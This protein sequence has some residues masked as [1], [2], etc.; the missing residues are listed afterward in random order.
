M[1]KLALLISFLVLPCQ[2]VGSEI[3]A[4]LCSARMIEAAK[5]V[6]LND[7]EMHSF[8]EDLQKLLDPDMDSALCIHF[9]TSHPSLRTVWPSNDRLFRV[10]TDGEI[11]QDLVDVVEGKSGYAYD[12]IRIFL[13]H[14]LPY[15]IEVLLVNASTPRTQNDPFLRAVELCLPTLNDQGVGAVSIVG[16]VVI[17]FGKEALK[18]RGPLFIST[19]QRALLHELFHIAQYQ[20]VAPG[21]NREISDFKKN[22]GPM[23]LLEGSALVFQDVRSEFC[24]ERGMQFLLDRNI[25][26]VTDIRA[27]VD[28]WQD[29]INRDDAYS[30]SHYST[31]SLFNKV[32]MHGIIE[33][34][35]ALG[36]GADWSEAFRDVFGISHEQFANLIEARISSE[37]GAVKNDNHVGKVD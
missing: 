5:E 22:F 10:S 19:V 11:E 24:K 23:W 30:I 26:G 3:G 32:G 1:R 20:L 27:Y 16:V 37:R 8:Q 29:E 34:Y 17:C 4:V 33:Y 7:S 36:K 13:E 9:G 14:D 18:Q 28:Y 31:C 12:R 15:T 6:N 35:A 2:A 21:S 25:A